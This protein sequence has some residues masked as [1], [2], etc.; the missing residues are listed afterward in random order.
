MTFCRCPLVVPQR[1]ANASRSWP[2]RPLKKVYKSMH[3]IKPHGVTPCQHHLEF[4][5]HEIGVMSDDAGIRLENLKKLKLG[6][7][8]LRDRLGSSY[9]L[10]SDLI[11]GRK[12]FGEK[13]ARRIEEGLVLPRGWLDA[14][15]DEVPVLPPLDQR[16]QMPQSAR[17]PDVG[18]AV[19]SEVMTDKH[20]KIMRMISKLDD[21][22]QQQVVGFIRG[23][24]AAQEDDD[25]SEA[26][27]EGRRRG[28]GVAG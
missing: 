11:K 12:S 28:N 23:L 24:L 26:P 9:S 1:W 16:R 15:S 14:A 10:W 8:D 19:E 27:A 22:K 21:P 5:V 20:Q 2:E 6:A 3:L 17:R 18:S 7:A 4:S 13:L 25:E